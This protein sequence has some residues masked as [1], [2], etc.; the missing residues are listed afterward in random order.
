MEPNTCTTYTYT[1]GP[2]VPWAPG[3]RTACPPPWDGPASEGIKFANKAMKSFRSHDMHFISIVNHFLGVCYGPFS[4]SSTS[5][6][7]KSRLQDD[8]LRL[9]QDA[10]AMAK[11]NPEIM[12][13]LAWENAMQRKLNAAVENATE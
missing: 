3:R 4:R 11:Y 9:L 12:Y 6:L 10:A 13:S 2:L 5:H 1:H 7:D 8:A